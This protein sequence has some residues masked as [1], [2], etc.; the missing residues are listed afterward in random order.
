MTRALEASTADRRRTSI[1]FAAMIV[2]LGIVLVGAGPGA[3]TRLL[4]GLAKTPVE[5]AAALLR[6]CLSCW[7]ATI[8]LIARVS[9]VL[10]EA[11]DSASYPW[12]AILVLGLAIWAAARKPGQRI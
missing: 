7:H 9:T 3:G 10:A 4:L 12:V 2:V 6:A 5:A 11:L 8:H 1:P